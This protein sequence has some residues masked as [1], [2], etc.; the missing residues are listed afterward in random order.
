MYEFKEINQ[1]NFRLFHDFMNEYYR[2]G[3]DTDTPQDKIDEF[4]K[5]L[6]DLIQ[7]K[8]LLGVLSYF[9]N[10]FIGIVIW[11]K[12]IEGHNF[13]KIPGHGTIVE[14][15]VIPSMRKRG[16]GCVL[17]DYAEQELLK[18]NINGIY[19]IAYGPALNFWRKRGY[20][21]SG[22]V[23]S[24]GLPILVKAIEKYEF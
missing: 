16:L 12:D 8:S 2:D 23:L 1:D 14:I 22:Q 10:I 9:D 4:I 17:A 18:L 11:M 21:E 3:E 20:I 5:N 24:N 6:F 15:G 19:V 7:E 13:S